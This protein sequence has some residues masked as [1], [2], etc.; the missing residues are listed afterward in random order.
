MTSEESMNNIPIISVTAKDCR[1]E[2]F[3][4]TGAGGQK[5]NKTSNCCRC[6]HEPSGAVGEARDSRSQR[7]NREEAFGKM[8][9]SPTFQRWLRLET[10]R[11]T[12]KE[13]EI[14]A[15]VDRQ[16]RKVRCD[17]KENGVWRE[18]R[19]EDFATAVQETTP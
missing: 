1:W 3:R 4:G 11:V 10:A 16:I 17:V 8:A 7:D 5:R 2:Y 6:T 13:M 12:G 9:R 19:D 15:E 18:A 14:N